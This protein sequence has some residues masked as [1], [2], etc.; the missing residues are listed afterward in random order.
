M[1]TKAQ[2]VK[3][4]V[5]AQERILPGDVAERKGPAEIRLPRKEQPK[6]EPSPTER[7]SDLASGIGQIKAV[8]PPVKVREERSYER[9][10]GWFD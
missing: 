3:E 4:V 6:A 2:Q 7:L 9:P 10:T 8:D 5:P 1:K